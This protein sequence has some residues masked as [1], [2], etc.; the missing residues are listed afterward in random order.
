M[1]LGRIENTT[2]K[3]SKITYLKTGVPTRKDPDDLQGNN[4]RMINEV[5]C[6]TIHSES[7]L[8]SSVTNPRAKRSGRDLR[9][10]KRME[11]F[12]IWLQFRREARRL[13]REEEEKTRTAG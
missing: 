1:G 3:E 7:L 10:R 12:R 13:E 9:M 11:I 6:R 5:N 4:T 8:I 2:S